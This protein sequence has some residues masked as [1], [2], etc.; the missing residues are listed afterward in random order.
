MSDVNMDALAEAH[1][2]SRDPQYEVEDPDQTARDLYEDVDCVFDD[3][4]A[5]KDEFKKI[6]KKYLV[7]CVAEKEV[8]YAFDELLDCL[9]DLKGVIASEIS[10]F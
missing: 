4:E 6:M 9:E 8:S 3:V 7:S 5:A 2:A 10:D 1:Y